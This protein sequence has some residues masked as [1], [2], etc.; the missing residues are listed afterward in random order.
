MQLKYCLTGLALSLVLCLVNGLMAPVHSTPRATILKQRSTQLQRQDVS[1]MAVDSVLANSISSDAAIIINKNS[2]QV[3][4]EKNA[5]KQEY[6]ASMTKMMTCLLA[7]EHSRL[8]TL[9]TIDEHAARAMDTNLCR[10]D[11]ITMQGLLYQL[12]LVSDNGAAVAIA[13]Y[14]ASSGKQTFADMMNQKARAIGMTASHFVTPNGLHDP[15]HYSTARDMA[16][17]ATYCMSNAAFRSIVGTPEVRVLWKRPAGKNL[18]CH[19]E[20]HLFFTYP[21]VNG[22]KTGYTNQARGCLATSFER[23]DTKLIVVVMHSLNG[24]TRFRDTKKLL[25]W[26]TEGKN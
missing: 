22:V 23:P 2:G 26:T 3:L 7:V 18:Y 11:H 17:L 25:D 5:D 12:M 24:Q 21:G 4:F 1:P 19:N 9:I 15:N 10:G 16:R 6:P 13:D 14:L 20:N 8:D